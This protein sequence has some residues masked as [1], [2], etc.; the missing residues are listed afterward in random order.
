MNTIRVKPSLFIL[1]CLAILFLLAS[2]SQDET[3]LPKNLGDETSQTSEVVKNEKVAVTGSKTWM[4]DFNSGELSTQALKGP[5]DAHQKGVWSEVFDW[6]F[7]AI[8]AAL[9][10]NGKVFSFGTQPKNLFN[11]L[12]LEAFHHDVWD[13]TKGVGLSSHQT[14]PNATSSN[15]FCGGVTLLPDGTLMIAGGDLAY[16]HDLNQNAFKGNAD[17]NLYNYQT[18]QLTKSPLQMTRG[19]W[20]PTLVNL[21]N[22]EVG[23]FGGYDVNQKPTTEVEIWNPKTGWRI[24]NG[25]EAFTTFFEQ[26]WSY[27]FVFTAPNGEVFFAQTRFAYLNTDTSTMRFAGTR[28]SATGMGFGSAV[29]Y[30]IGKILI[31]GGGNNSIAR[32]EA[33]TIDIN[34][35]TPAWK[36]VA[37]MSSPR[38][39]PD[40]TLLA[41]GQIFVNGGSNRG[42]NAMDSI[43]Y[44]SEI[45]NPATEKW[46]PSAS[47]SRS[48]MYHSTALLLP[49]A[50]VLTVGGDRPE[51]TA[52]FNG[53]IYY[54]P[55]LFKNDGSGELAPRPVIQSVQTFT[56]KDAF[57]LSFN[58]ANKVSKV[59]F[60]KTGAT[61]HSW[62]M[63]QRFMSLDFKQ[64]G[65][66]LTLTAPNSPDIAPPGYYLIFIFD[67]NGV[68][69]EGKIVNLQN[70]APVIKNP[71]KQTNKFNDSVGLNLEASDP[72]G[73]KITYTAKGLPTGLTLN[74]DNG[75]IRGN[76]AAFGNFAVTVTVTNQSGFARDISF[77]WIISTEGI[78]DLVL[79]PLSIS[80]KETGSVTY[81][82]DFQGG[83]NPKF[84]WSFDNEAYGAYSSLNTITKAFAKPGHYAISVMATDDT[85]KEVKLETQQLIYNPFTT[86]QAKSS[87]SIFYDTDSNHIWK[88]NPDN[89]SVTVMDAKT[90]SKI[91]E[92]P[93]G[94]GPRALTQLNH[95][96]W[97]SNKFDASLTVINK[98]TLETIRTL[99]LPYASQPYGIVADSSTDSVYVVL[100]ALGEVLKLDSS[101]AI[102]ARVSAGA[103]PRHISLSADNKILVTRYITAPVQDE[104]STNQNLAKGAD[105]MIFSSTL[106]LE[107]TVVL[108]KVIDPLATITGSGI[109]NYLGAP[110]ISPDGKTAWIPSK[111]DDITRGNFR[112]GNNLTF[113]HTVRSISSPV[114][115]VNL[116][117]DVTKRIDFD[118]GGIASA[119]VFSH[120]GDYLF[121]ALEG[122]REVAVVDVYNN[123]ELFR[124]ETG[125]APQGL[126]L[127]AD[128]LTLYVDNFMARTVSVHD[129]SSLVNDNS[130]KPEAVQLITTI[131]SVDNE[132]LSSQILRG[133]QLFYDAADDRI[134]K[135]NYIS[136]AS[137][138]N[139][140]EQDGRVWDFTGLG[141]GLRNTISLRG[142]SG[143]NHGPLHWSG[144]FDE[145]QDFEGQ[146]R[147]LG[148]GTGLLSDSLFHTGTRADP[149]GDSKAGLS[150][151]LDA[152]A[153]YVASLD[154]FA[155]SPYRNEDG[156]LSAEAQ[157][158]KRIFQSAGCIACHSGDNFSDSAL[159][160][161]HDIGTIKASSGKRLNT[162]LD[163]LDTPTLRDVWATAPYLH[164]G[165]ATTL[166]D[167]VKA[168]KDV[169]L[170]DNETHQLVSYLLQIDGSED[171]PQA[172]SD[173]KLTV[174]N[175]EKTAKLSASKGQKDISALTF[176][177]VADKVSTLTSFTLSV[178]GSGN[179][180]L[181]INAVSLYEDNNQDG[182]VDT[183]DNKLVVGTFSEDNGLLTLNLASDL[184]L[185]AG[186][187]IHF[188]VTVD[189]S[190]TLAASLYGSS[191]ALALFGFGLL[192]LALKRKR[193]VLMLIILLASILSACSSSP[194]PPQ[195]IK[196]DTSVSYQ[197]SL[198]NL[199]GLSNEKE[200][201]STGLPIKGQE[202]IVK[203]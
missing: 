120:Y 97:V 141:E 192:G 152:M 92:I 67:E 11:Y 125:F 119:A 144:N 100:E 46:S 56:Y 145:V 164:D 66:S 162:K 199:S 22:G 158:G 68:P 107:T 168:H 42:E 35:E 19:R 137:C 54:P 115:L 155:A 49:D 149:L 48:R 13:P 65:S 165:S 182:K 64:N 95:Q 15:I 191:A 196:D 172:L 10:P 113:E 171:A 78:P 30:D 103:N 5:A 106:K 130:H 122:S 104:L 102:Q 85:G 84:R 153:A 134:G 2:C 93:V 70:K 143:M 135:D 77:N 96:I 181:D 94:Q 28:P 63:S 185:T 16:E 188:I 24:L 26:N 189:I 73:E 60:I 146:M 55:Y 40:A 83:L 173:T 53:E 52:N 31:L 157:I 138:H 45:W 47:A 87:S 109:A 139:D 180:A 161:R 3:S 176:T 179:D 117:S 201:F 25:L 136:C 32:A 160:V 112:D 124:F 58:G 131:K 21:P 184:T 43:I 194:V 183:G 7:I 108:N 8:H 62:N 163:G 20:Y 190:D 82:V 133:K 127:S 57:S 76:V 187:T 44:Q 4:Q 121:V 61:T 186:E 150:E 18:G 41:D 75:Q 74:S 159:N 129:I 72:Q 178:S 59:S 156:S 69:S 34:G 175:L 123:D 29:M 9:L 174:T 177:V 27:P 80:P 193:V 17:L 33:E 200:V 202:I 198:E 89:N 110:V 88:V 1:F 37:A 203:K 51:E 98:N 105:L 114:D 6:P 50:T 116:A 99:K 71:G 197:L 147:T 39:Y 167:A 126:A 90:N 142:R 169:K 170:T 128:G 91:Q 140:G 154:T 166:A 14:L 12:E 81:S 195:V 148:N 132:L 38:K 36:K 111:Q 101:G 118:N 23:V 86:K 79:E 151:D